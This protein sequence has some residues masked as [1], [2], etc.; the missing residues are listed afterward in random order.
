M[1]DVS[2]FVLTDGQRI[3]C[4]G[5]GKQS[6]TKVFL[7]DTGSA[8]GDVSGSTKRVNSCDFKP[9]RPFRVATASED[10]AVSFY[11]GPVRAYFNPRTRN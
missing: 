8:I 11:E 3:V 6:F 5:Q 2:C 7:W 9:S 4:C 10:F 1:T